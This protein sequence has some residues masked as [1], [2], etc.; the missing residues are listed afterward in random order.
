MRAST[1][2]DPATAFDFDVRFRIS[3]PYHTVGGEADFDKFVGIKHIDQPAAGTDTNVFVEWTPADGDKPHAC[4]MVDLINLVGTDTNANDNWAQENLEIVASVTAQPVPPGD[5]QLQPDESVQ[6]ASAVL[7]PRRRR[8]E[9]LEGRTHSAQDP[10]GSRRA[11]GRAGD[12]HAARGR[13]GVHAAS[14]CR[15]RAGRRAATRSSTSAAPSCRWTCGARRSSP[16]GRAGRCAGKD[17]EILFE[18]GEEAGQEARPGDGR[19][20]A[21][22]SAS[23]A[24]TT[25]RSRNRRSSSSTSIRSGNVT[26]HTVKTDA[27]GCFEDFMVSRRPARG[28]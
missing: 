26:F 2:P 14:A 23:R 1:T 12:H 17:W 3:E 24:A 9:G 4:V 16:R 20:A 27:N 18:R 11:H 6:I 28:R 21:D 8:A 25:R 19:R 10:A 5:L 13:R 7:L 15:S 22:A